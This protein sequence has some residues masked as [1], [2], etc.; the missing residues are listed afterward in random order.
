MA[1]EFDTLDES[2]NNDQVAGIEQPITGAK[3]GLNWMQ[4]QRIVEE[5]RYQ[6][7]WRQEADKAVDYYDGNQLDSETLADLESKGMA[8]LLT[9][10]IKPT[11][12]M[13]L[14]MEA[15]T[16]SDWRVVADQAEFQDVAEALSQK[17][18]EAERETRADRACSDAYAGQI[19][20]GLGWVE[21]S[22]N[23]D[24]FLY[25][26][27]CQ[28]V[29]RRE[30]FW[31]WV[32][33]QPDLSDAR[34][35]VR[36]RWFDLDEVELHFPKHKDVLTAAMGR[37]GGNWITAAT[38]NAT[39]ANAFDQERGTTVSDFEW[40]NPRRARI[41]LFEIWY[42]THVRGKILRLPDRVVEFDKRNPMH[43][44]AVKTG[45]V[46]PEDAIYRRMNLSIW[47][48]PHRL[49]DGKSPR[50]RMPYVPF[51]GYR[52]DLTNVPYG[53]IR[54]MISPQDEINARR[55][56]LMNLLSSKRIIADSDALDTRVNAFSDVI[57]EIARPDSVVVLNPQRRN[58]NAF[59]VQTELNLGEQQFQIMQESKEVLQQA[60]GVY[61]AMLG[62]DSSATSGLAINSL[63]E[64][65]TTTLAE[66]NDNYR[67][68]RRMVGEMLVDM[69]RDDMVGKP[70]QVVVGEGKRKLTII[71]NQPVQDPE[72]GVPTVVNDVS[73][74][75]VKVAL[76]DVP[77]TPAYRAQQMTML[78]QV[79]SS[80]PDQAKMLL[81]PSFIE[82][83]EL[84]NRIEVS[85][86]LRSMLG[87]QS[88]GDED[89][90][91][92][93]MM[94]QLQQAEQAI[95]QLQQAPQMITAQAKQAE[96]ELKAQDQQIRAQQAQV[97][98][99][100]TQAEIA[101][102]QAETD[103]TVTDAALGTER[104]VIDMQG[105]DLQNRQ[106]ALASE[107]DQV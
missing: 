101:K 52:E 9:N 41:C 99:Q 107:L 66:I 53:L 75:E 1:S 47:A 7:Q 62:Q 68:S 24:P 92:A 39:L 11:I 38:E 23:A 58:A 31:D 40:V 25:P 4:Y 8:P 15:K 84:P 72:T 91:K 10:L 61:Q 5:I 80:L 100:K 18:S 50:K 16:R 96:I 45:A 105:R 104:H 21:V 97:D 55:R 44:L 94:Q 59:E 85:E 35:I 87:M 83:S 86:Q 82:M 95:Q 37:W 27:R 103:K 77:S 29:H 19:K 57:D 49:Y 32:A 60:A 2:Y 12:D 20:S 36:K 106:A 33:K 63:V 48:G 22:R 28:P 89:P 14:G 88:E 6:P 67:Y 3:G 54:S 70:V 79:M 102:I 51:W 43:Q 81:T 42:A 34:Y 98:M 73:R 46:Q 74:T 13:I 76:E 71:L 17:L 69:I 26:Y 30:I 65:G 64:Q 93:Q 56:K 90:E 78:T